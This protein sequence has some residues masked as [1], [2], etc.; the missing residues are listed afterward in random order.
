MCE[1]TGAM[2]QIQPKI[3]RH[4]AQLRKFRILDDHRKGHW[5]FYQIS[6]EL[7]EWE[8]RVLDTTLQENQELIAESSSRLRRMQLDDAICEQ[9]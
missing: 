5:V 4:L 9:A 6:D 1:L 8:R 7:P 2:D 3:S